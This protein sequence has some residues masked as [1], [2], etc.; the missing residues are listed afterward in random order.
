MAATT[1]SQALRELAKLEERVEER[2]TD[3]SEPVTDT[4][5][6]RRVNFLLTR[7]AYGLLDA[8][9]RQAARRVHFLLWGTPEIDR[10]KFGPK[11]H[12]PTIC[13]DGGRP[14]QLMATEADAAQWG[15]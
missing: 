2:V 7:E 13:I 8:V 11:H 10:A 3:E 9:G 14:N 12:C 4:D 5:V 15:Y 1:M 6:A